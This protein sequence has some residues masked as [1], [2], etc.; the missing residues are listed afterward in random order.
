MMRS[1]L[2]TLDRVVIN[3]DKAVKTKAQFICKRLQVP[4]LGFPVD[5]GSGKM[6]F[7]QREVRA[8]FKYLEHILFIVL[9]A[10]AKQHA[11]P[12][13]LHHELL[14]VLP[15]PVQNKTGGSVLS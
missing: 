1:Y 4:G 9:A 11:G 3:E 12:M 14:H 10:Q 13:L 5:P 6:F 8:A 2:G 7:S 15:A